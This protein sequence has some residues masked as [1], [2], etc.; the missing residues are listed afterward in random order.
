MA[1]R[2]LHDL[3]DDELRIA[4]YVETPHSKLDGDLQAVDESFI[5]GCVV[6]GDEVEP[7]HVAHM[8][9]EGEMK[10]RPAP[11]PVFIIDPS[12]YMVQHSAWI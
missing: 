10:S 5:L 12:K 7:N 4:P 1:V 2:L 8:H 6:G 3:V 11:A 9:S